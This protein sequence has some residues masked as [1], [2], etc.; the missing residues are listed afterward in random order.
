MAKK[1]IKKKIASAKQSLLGRYFWFYIL[2]SPWLFYQ[3][4]ESLAGR[5]RNWRSRS[6]MKG[7][8][9]LIF[10]NH[11]PQ[12]GARAT[13]PSSWCQ[14]RIEQQQYDKRDEEE[15][16]LDL[17]SDCW[18]PEKLP[19][20]LKIWR[21]NFFLLKVHTSLSKG[22]PQTVSLL[23]WK[24]NESRPKK[25]LRVKKKHGICWSSLMVLWSKA[26]CESLKNSSFI[27]HFIFLK[28]K[29]AMLPLF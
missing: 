27:P 6:Y 18:A 2:T 16:C 8:P 13:I 10:L 12:V 20:K 5:R 19:R 15:T 21:S 28:I 29:V 17:I 14:V 23:V 24:L 9:C 4:G 3:K 1:W 11:L 7:N 22:G 26:F 25:K